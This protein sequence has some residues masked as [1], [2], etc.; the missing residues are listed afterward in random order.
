M[1]I[2]LNPY[3][4]LLVSFYNKRTSILTNN[5]H[6]KY[7]QMAGGSLNITRGRM[8]ILDIMEYHKGEN[9]SIPMFWTSGNRTSQGGRTQEVGS[10]VGRSLIT[11]HLLTEE[12]CVNELVSQINTI[13]PPR[14]TTGFQPL[15]D[16]NTSKIHSRTKLRRYQTQ[17]LVL[18]KDIVPA[19]MENNLPWE[20]ANINDCNFW[21]REQTHISLNFLSFLFYFL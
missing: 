10:N 4:A 20:Y 7:F 17:Y 19:R 11:E 6:N 13:S 21:G 15:V 8:K 16:I 2:H 9:L 3:I 18:S 1:R 14:L 12:I 5:K